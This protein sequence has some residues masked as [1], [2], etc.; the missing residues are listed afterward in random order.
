LKGN[1]SD[2]PERSKAK[3]SKAK[4]SKAK[5]SKAKQSGNPG[6]V[7]PKSVQPDRV[8][9]PQRPPATGIAKVR[10]LLADS[11]VMFRDGL[12]ALLNARDDIVVVAQ[13][14]TGPA[15]ARI[16]RGYPVDIAV[17]ED[18]LPLFDGPETARAI[19][20]DNARLRVVVVARSCTPGLVRRVLSAGARGFLLRSQSSSS[21]VKAIMDVHTV[22]AHMCKQAQL[23]AADEFAGGETRQPTSPLDALL[24]VERQVALLMAQD[25]P[26]SEIAEKLCVSPRTLERVRQHLRTKLG[27]RTNA[28]IVLALSRSVRDE[29]TCSWAGSDPTEVTAATPTRQG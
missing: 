7:V 28:G 19:I 15:A 18:D 26:A 3:Q 11:E 9:S 14:S 22:R 2:R 10:V 16:C 6:D 4:Q 20:A 12:A 23:I 1:G 25:L 27:V 21:L 17:L 24:P 29:A 5:Q 13:A 8:P